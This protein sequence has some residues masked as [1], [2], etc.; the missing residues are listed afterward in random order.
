MIQVIDSFRDNRANPQL[1]KI[2]SMTKEF[3]EEWKKTLCAIRL[4]F[5]KRYGDFLGH[6]GSSHHFT[7]QM[8]KLLWL[9]EKEDIRKLYVKLQNAS[10]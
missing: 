10:Q 5:E 6:G 3:T 9:N 4:K 7:R 2:I 1:A 8:K